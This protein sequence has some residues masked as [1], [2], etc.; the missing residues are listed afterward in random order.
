MM[1]ASAA[2]LWR[3]AATLETL[4]AR[5]GILDK[6]RIFFQKR[7]VLEVTTPVMVS[8]LAPERHQNPPVCAGRF[9]QG[10]PETAMKRL[11]AAG[12]GPIFQI[13]PA[14]RA[15]EAGRL[16]NPEFTM[17]EWYRP[18]WE[19][20]RLI[21]EVWELLQSVLDCGDAEVFTFQEAFI[22]LVGLDPVSTGTAEMRAAISGPTPS[23]LDRP[24]LTDLLLVEKLEPAL[25]ER[26]GAVFIT[27]YPAWEPLMAEVD[28]GPP[29][30]ARRFELYVDGV[31]LANGYQELT[32]AVEQKKRLDAANRQ[33][34][35]DGG[36]PL[37]VDER[38][39]AAMR[40]GLPRC[41][42]VAMGI[43]RLIM[44][45]LGKNSIGAVMAFP[46]DRS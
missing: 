39:L 45:A 33:R 10:S 15:D 4:A 43:D 19:M 36:K 2:E 17:L 29:P 18:G 44:L 6:L 1:T 46:A 30:L 34:L 20:E 22:R 40:H 3:P 5:A 35:E 8:A 11:L 23:D 32:D 24:G 7:G 26:G 27:D 37:P 9:L 14:F 38:F 41:S 21:T 28:S 42:G 31:E 13:C 16:H 12:S 25:R